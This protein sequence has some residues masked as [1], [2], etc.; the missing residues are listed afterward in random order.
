MTN[1]R[2]IFSRFFRLLVM[3][4]KISYAHFTEWN[5]KRKRKAFAAGIYFL[6]IL[7][8]FVLLAGTFLAAR[9]QDGYVHLVNV[10]QKVVFYG[11]AGLAVLLSAIPLGF[12]DDKKICKEVRQELRERPRYWKRAIAVYWAVIV[13]MVAA[14]NIV[15]PTFSDKTMPPE[16]ERTEVPQRWRDYLSLRFAIVY[17]PIFLTT[18][19]FL[20]D[21]TVFEWF[22]VAMIAGIVAIL[23]YLSN[24]RIYP[25]SRREAVMQHYEGRRFS[26]F[27]CYFFLFSLGF[28]MI[29]EMYLLPSTLM[30]I[31]GRKA[32][33]VENTR[34]EVPQRWRDYLALHI[35][36]GARQEVPSEALQYLINQDGRT[37]RYGQPVYVM[38]VREEDMG[39][40]FRVGLLNHAT[41][42]E[43]QDGSQKFVE[44]TWVKG[45]TPDSI[46][47]LLTGWYE[48]RN[49][50]LCPVDSL[51][52]TE[53]TEF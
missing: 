45:Y 29:A 50:G 19:H 28:L 8:E 41:F 34:T 42:D 16:N 38:Q 4:H 31:D 30:R 35:T 27:R 3:L 44:C 53:D 5:N 15:F 7:P 21:S 6:S 14:A 46:R 1:R 17:E 12:F 22:T 24:G 48:V 36:V 13:A 18:A 2:N 11:L 26:P 47:V 9:G 37:S 40:E 43:I 51:E 49:T 20:F 25:F 32:E 23:H 52:W 10:P 33:P 39:G